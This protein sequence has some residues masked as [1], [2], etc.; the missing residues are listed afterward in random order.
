MNQSARLLTTEWFTAWDRCVPVSIFKMAAFWHIE[1]SKYAIYTESHNCVCVWVI[2]PNVASIGQSFWVMSKMIFKTAF[3]HQSLFVNDITVAHRSDW[4]L[5]SWYC[6]KF[7]R[8]FL[9]IFLAKR[10]S[11]LAFWFGMAWTCPLLVKV[12][13]THVICNHRQ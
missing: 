2:S 10:I 5:C 12:S 7:S 3:I 4:K 13:N 6:A 8:E 1:F 9:S 11:C